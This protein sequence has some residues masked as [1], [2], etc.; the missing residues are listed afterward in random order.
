M[1]QFTR[2]LISSF[3]LT[4]GRLITSLVLCYLRF[5][6]VCKKRHRFAQYL[7][8]KCSNAFVQSAVNARRQGDENT[9]SSVVAEAMKVLANIPYGHQILD[10]SLPTV[11]KCLNVYK[12]LS[13][14]HSTMFRRLSHF[15][16]Q[17]YEVELVKTQTEREKPVIIG[18]LIYNTPNRECCNFTT[19]SSKSF[20]TLTNMDNLKWTQTPS[21][22]LRRRNF[23]TPYLLQKAR[24]VEC[25]AFGRLHGHYCSQCNIFF[26]ECVA[27]HT[28][29]TVRG[30]QV[31]LRKNL[32]VQKCCIYAVK[33]IVA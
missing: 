31:T 10:C 16:D 30:N 18:F 12:T 26:S 5:G 27:T 3:H 6:L 1:A 14:I 33:P 11:T 15:T 9:N 25:D 22:W 21:T 7:L 8:K 2:M 19:S 20:V 28:R 23:G 32:D 13:A 4:N 24:Q 17:L 29:N